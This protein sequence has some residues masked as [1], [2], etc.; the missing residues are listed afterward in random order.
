MVKMSGVR[1]LLSAL[2]AV[3]S[4]TVFSEPGRKAG[5]QVTGERDSEALLMGSSLLNVPVIMDNEA[6]TAE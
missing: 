1:G 5:E 4:Q 3:I 6:I 2:P